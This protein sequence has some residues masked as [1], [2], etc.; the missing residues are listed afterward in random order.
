MSKF[1]DVRI[2]LSNFKDIVSNE[3]FSILKYAERTDSFFQ[4]RCFD[5]KGETYKINRKKL[6]KQRKD[7]TLDRVFFTDTIV[8]YNSIKHSNGNRYSFEFNVRI[9]EGLI[10]D[11]RLHNFGQGSKEDSEENEAK[12][13]KTLLQKFLDFFDKTFN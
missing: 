13:K 10:E 9:E 3:Q 5:C 2:P 1:D 8:V 7:G 6:Y 12:P 4:T 11:I